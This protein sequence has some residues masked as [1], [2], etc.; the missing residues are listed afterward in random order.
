MIDTGTQ[1]FLDLYVPRDK[2]VY[3]PPAIEDPL[4]NMAA[5]RHLEE[6]AA[7]EL[8]SLAEIAHIHFVG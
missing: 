3:T 6:V 7:L 4:G 1:K 2:L 8:E 5:V